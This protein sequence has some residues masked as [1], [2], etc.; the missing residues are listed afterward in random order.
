MGVHPGLRRAGALCAIGAILAALSCLAPTEVTLVL[1]TDVPC[2][3]N[4]GTMITVGSAADVASK[5]PVTVTQDC[6]LVSAGV[7]D[8]GALTTPA[9]IGTLVVTPSGG[10]SDSFAVRIVTA[11]DP[12]MSPT[13]CVPPYTNC[14]VASR[15]VSF[16]PHTPITLPIEIRLDCKNISCAEGQTCDHGRCLPDTTTV[17]CSGSACNASVQ[18]DASTPLDSGPPAD[19]STDTSPVDV[20]VDTRV[21]DVAVGSTPNDATADV[22]SDVAVDARVD[23]GAP[24]EGGSAT[25]A[26]P[27]GSCTD[28]GP[29]GAIAC[30]GGTCSTTAGNVCCIT[31]PQA[32]APSEACVPAG[33]CPSGSAGYPLHESISCRSGGDCQPGQICCY[34]AGAGA[35]FNALCTTVSS[36]PVF[37][38]RIGCRNSCECPGANMC[39]ALPCWGEDIGLCGNGGASCP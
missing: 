5:P 30:A 13:D 9:S 14:I 1:T 10:R 19:A 12:T 11:V 17:I 20:S 38:D 34:Q 22:S 3:L 21:L 27:L 8:S 6:T 23:V 15:E 37:S 25:D 35:G 29:S 16:V 2:L 39:Y 18:E 28:A 24:S 33:M 32:A 7:D 4:R 26:N 31:V 36:C